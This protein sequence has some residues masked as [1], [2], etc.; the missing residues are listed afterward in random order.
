MR[1]LLNL[2]RKKQK[3][4]QAEHKQGNPSPAL[5]AQPQCEANILDTNM[6]TNHMEN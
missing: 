4:A 3:L 2:T 1:G 6:E 5:P